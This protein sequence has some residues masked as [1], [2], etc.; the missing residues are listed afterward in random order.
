[1]CFYTPLNSVKLTA[2]NRNTIN[3]VALQTY[4]SESHYDGVKWKKN[5]VSEIRGKLK[6]LSVE[7]NV[8]RGER[9]PSELREI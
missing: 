1:M 5:A 9:P 7:F 8:T 4:L 2:Q 3:C 6:E